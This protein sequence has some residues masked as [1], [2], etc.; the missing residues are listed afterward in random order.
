MQRNDA[1]DSGWQF[2]AQ[3]E[4]AARLLDTLLAL[5]AGTPYT[6]TEIAEA[7]GI[8]LK[9]LYLSGVLEECAD[10]DVL[11]RVDDEGGEARYVVNEES[12]LLE[13]AAAFDDAYRNQQE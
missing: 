2:V 6:K 12:A 1:D 7:A 13:A 3:R 4:S 10:L 5:D 8:P 9:T 11:Q